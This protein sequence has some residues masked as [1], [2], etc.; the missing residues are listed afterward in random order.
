MGWWTTLLLSSNLKQPFKV[1]YWPLWQPKKDNYTLQ[2]NTRA[3]GGH[4]DTQEVLF[5]CLLQCHLAGANA[6]RMKHWSQKRGLECVGSWLW[7]QLVQRGGFALSP[8]EVTAVRPGIY[9]LSR[10]APAFQEPFTHKHKIMYL[11]MSLYY[12]LPHAI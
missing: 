7:H 6:V 9:L 3:W 1:S 10:G 4:R 2:T 12:A 5:P 8:M 11:L